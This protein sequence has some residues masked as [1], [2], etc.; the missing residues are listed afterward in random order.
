MEAYPENVEMDPIPPLDMELLKERAAIGSRLTLLTRWDGLGSHVRALLA[1][2]AH[3][4]AN[5]LTYIHTPWV[6][7]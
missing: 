2:L 6:L 1:I 3:C 4:R 5:N 7:G